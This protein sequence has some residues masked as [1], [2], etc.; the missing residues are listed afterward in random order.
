MESEPMYRKGDLPEQL[1]QAMLELL[2][3]WQKEGAPADSFV[4]I[5][6]DEVGQLT[7]KKR[8][9]LRKG[10]WRR[11]SPDMEAAIIEGE[12]RNEG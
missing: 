10:P 12:R 5:S 7:I 4:N 8:I 6:P 11:F 1:Q 9:S 3:G 2:N